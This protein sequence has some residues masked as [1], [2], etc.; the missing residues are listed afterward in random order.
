M[1]QNDSGGRRKVAALLASTALLWGLA[2]APAVAGSFDSSLTGV[3]T[4]F[5]SRWWSE[6]GTGT[7][8]TRV[9]FSYCS[10]ASDIDWRAVFDK[11]RVHL[12]R[13]NGVFPDHN[14]GRAVSNCDNTWASWGRMS[15]AGSYKWTVGQ[16]W[17]TYGGVDD[18]AWVNANK[19]TVPKLRTEW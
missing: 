4:G 2:S 5:S 19:L 15:S 11:A 16:V 1:M 3:A 17:R 14:H 18:H 10:N 6:N 12:W 9:R 13:D 7:A 8:S